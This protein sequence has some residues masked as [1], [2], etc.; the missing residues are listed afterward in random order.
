[1]HNAFMPEAVKIIE[2]VPLKDDRACGL[3]W[4]KQW[5]KSRLN[6]FVFPFVLLV[7]SSQSYLKLIDQFQYRRRS[8]QT[9]MMRKC[10]TRITRRQLYLQV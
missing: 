1:M 5:L 8:D 3:L 4:L 2:Q 10:W 9:M 6:I 7:F